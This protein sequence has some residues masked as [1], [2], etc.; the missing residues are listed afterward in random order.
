[1]RPHE[2]AAIDLALS[3]PCWSDPEGARLLGG[4]KT[5]LNMVLSDQGR[6]FV[7][8]L[9]KD[10]P[11][12]GVM[13]WNELAV[14]RAT[15]AAGLAPA[16]HYAEA[17]VLVLD[18]VDADPLDEAGVRDPENLLRIVDL[19]ARIHRDALVYLRGPVLA[20]WVFHI[21]R[22]YAATLT[23]RGSAHSGLLP[24]LLAQAE[25]LEAMVGPIT[26]VLGH[27]DLLASNIL[28]GA[29]RLWLIDWEYAGMNSPLFDLGGLA[30]NNGF[31]AAQEAAMLEAYFG[32]APTP[33]LWRSYEAMKCASLLRETLWSMVSEITSDIDFDY[34][35]YTAAKLTNYRAAFAGLQQF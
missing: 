34:A 4:G 14:S 31:S 2:Q 17:G 11:E 3:L 5:N 22:D 13:R 7:V 24:G 21:L 8:R 26:L 20:F 18:Y 1:M 35:D 25:R 15:H 19:V 29:D 16:V 28:K 10:I 32:A 30:T 27:N 6:R 9:G 33:S 12:H 23:A